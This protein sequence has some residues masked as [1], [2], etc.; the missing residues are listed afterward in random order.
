MG[1]TSKK[2]LYIY[3]LDFRGNYSKDTG[4]S[5]LTVMVLS[6]AENGK[7]TGIVLINPPKVS[8]TLDQKVSLDEISK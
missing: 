8:D 4:S 3:Q 6:A 1:L 5:R 7:H 2:L